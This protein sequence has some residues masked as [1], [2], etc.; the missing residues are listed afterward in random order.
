LDIKLLS[1]TNRVSFS[2][3][4]QQTNQTL[5]RLGSQGKATSLRKWQSTHLHND[6]TTAKFLESSLNYRALKNKKPH[7]KL[8]FICYK[9]C[10]LQKTQGKDPH[11]I[12]SGQMKSKKKPSIL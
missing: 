8:V 11:K 1:C 10:S 7:L 4:K 5:I 12:C 9:F 6:P 3:H 2:L